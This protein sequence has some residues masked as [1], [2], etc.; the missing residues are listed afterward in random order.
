MSQLLLFLY[1]GEREWRTQT[2]KGVLKLLCYYF[3]QSAHYQ[4]IY[5]SLSFMIIFTLTLTMLI[6]ISMLGF[7]ATSFPFSIGALDSYKFDIP[8]PCWWHF[9]QCIVTV[10]N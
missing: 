7:M 1:S 4:I 6:K 10:K 8:S 3:G 9:L 2:R 5:Y